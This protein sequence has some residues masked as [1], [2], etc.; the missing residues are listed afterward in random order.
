MVGRGGGYARQ[1]QPPTGMGDWSGRRFDSPRRPRPCQTESVSLILSAWALK[2]LSFMT[3]VET[4]M[5][6]S[7]MNCTQDV[8][9]P[10]S[11]IAGAACGCC[12]M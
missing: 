12:S 4:P 10:Y 9:P 11:S 6:Y 2:R 7:S 5:G 8:Q 3:G 1:L